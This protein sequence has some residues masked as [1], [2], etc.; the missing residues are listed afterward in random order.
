MAEDGL[1][2]D[3]RDFLESQRIECRSKGC[4][5][6]VYKRRFS[7]DYSISPTNLEEA[8]RESEGSHYGQEEDRVSGQYDFILYPTNV[9]T[10]HNPRPGSVGSTDSISE[11]IGQSGDSLNYPIN[12]PTGHNLRPDSVGSADSIPESV[13]QFGDSSEYPSESEAASSLGDGHPRITP[14]ESFRSHFLS[15]L[16]PEGLQHTP[17]ANGKMNSDSSYEE[18]PG[19]LM[20]AVNHTG[21]A[22]SQDLS[23]SKA[24]MPHS[25]GY[26]FGREE[27][28]SPFRWGGTQPLD[29][30][31]KSK[32]AS[33]AALRSQFSG[34]FCPFSP[35][36]SNTPKR[37]NQSRAPKK[38]VNVPSHSSS[39]VSKY[40]R[41]QLN[42]PLPDFSKVEPRVR[43]PKAE[44]TYRPPKG[45]NHSRQFQG[46]TRPLVFKSPAEIVR[47]VLLSSGDNSPQKASLPSYTV[48]RVPKEFKTPQQATELV[49]QLQEDYHRLLTKYAEA[50]NTIDQLRL[51][52]K[53]N[54]YSDPP[55]PS[56]GVHMG[57]MP[58]GTKVMSF[59]IPQ[60]RMAE[61]QSTTGS[62][63]LLDSELSAT[64]GDLNPSPA[65][66]YPGPLTEGSGTS[67]LG[68]SLGDRLTQTLANEV[69]RFLAQVESFEGLVQEG[70]LPPQDQLKRFWRLKEEQ[71]ALE[72]SFLWA[73]GEHRR[74]QQL[75]A[76]EV[77]PGKFDPNREVEGEIFR[78]GMRLE[79][80]MDE[81]DDLRPDQ[82][83][84]RTPPE[85]KSRGSSAASPVSDLP[86]L[87]PALS[88][89]AP[90]PAVCTPY[91]ETPA[92]QN[93]HTFLS[94]EH[95]EVSSASSEVENESPVLPQPLQYKQ[96]QMEQDF[97]SLMARCHSIKL[98]PDAV[99]LEEDQEEKNSTQE[100]D[101]PIAGNPNAFESSSRRTEQEKGK[102]PNH[103][104]ECVEQT[105]ST[106]P[107]DLQSS[108]GNGGHHLD[109]LPQGPVAQPPP[110]APQLTPPVSEQKQQ[111]SHQSS[112]AS[113]AG[114]GASGSLPLQKAFHLAST[115]Q[116]ARNFDV[117]Q[118]KD[119]RIVSPETDSGFVGSETSRISP[120][121]QTP[122]HQLSHTSVSFGTS[123]PRR[124][125][126]SSTA[127][128]PQAPSSHHP[129]RD[130]PVIRV[131]SGLSTS[132]AQ[133]QR[134]DPMPITP[135]K[136]WTKSFHHKMGPGTKMAHLDGEG[137]DRAREQ[138]SHGREDDQSPAA[139]PSDETPQEAAQHPLSNL[140]S[141]EVRD[142]AIRALQQEVTRLR[143]RIEA[144]LNSPPQDTSSHNFQ[145]ATRA[146]SRL[147]KE[148]LALGSCSHTSKSAER[149]QSDSGDTTQNNSTVRVQLRSSSVP[150]EEP[151]PAQ[152]IPASESEQSISRIQAEESRGEEQSPS[153]R[154][155]G[156]TKGKQ[157]DTVYFRG[158][159]T[160]HEYSVKSSQRFQADN[161]SHSC[162]RCH[163][164]R[165]KLPDNTLSKDPEELFPSDSMKKTQC[166]MCH[167]PRNPTERDK[168]PS[169][170][171]KGTQKGAPLSSGPA[172]KSEQRQQQSTSPSL[173]HPPGVWYLAPPLPAP[174][175]AT[176]AYVPPVPVVPYS[177]ST[178]YYS[179]VAPT[180]ASSPLHYSSGKK[181][182]KVR[183]LSQ[184]HRTP[185]PIPGHRCLSEMDLVDLDDLSLS[186]SQAVEAAKNVELTTKQMSRSLSADLHRARGL[187]GSCLF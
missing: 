110:P 148:P 61:W 38:G 121:T 176:F 130:K 57:S 129:G 177:P 126:Q 122:E 67:T 51:G 48:A 127:C 90:M 95:T 32:K 28:N 13:G 70:T 9:P 92:L 162:P 34:S 174:A 44:E 14:T 42:Y 161:N 184:S 171:D 116:L 76:S 144:S 139:T 31:Q 54:L 152:T 154:I 119:H 180:S 1:S 165:K 33:P 2:R 10:E 64:R 175:G 185:T 134:S 147:A 140:I 83:S 142:Q 124:L 29:Q 133:A 80:L 4:L 156:G 23:N 39:E 172:R 22:I 157:T 143:E 69:V 99:K 151:Q 137:H 71:D 60:A 186:L 97:Q 120:L 135:P 102:H 88:A 100:V 105:Q 73:R 56:H 66:A 17:S 125:P 159:Y 18:K 115:P 106:Q 173:P 98:F 146:Q 41:G 170:I 8:Q 25:P 62:Q 72:K 78:L 37:L 183:P 5:Q 128:L 108:P 94:G 149:Y 118:Y 158:L 112:I 93:G 169:G 131:S 49:Q 46:P 114:S 58:H 27:S 182:A 65:V 104:E 164:L 123:D 109:G 87:S 167:R 16:S 15:C 153:D 20:G 178:L 30:I 79:E 24:Q 91:P 6:R 84:L 155:K 166:P 74:V 181:P 50:E 163:S 52:A 187:R 150:W 3:T 101:G 82:L 141:R 59:T 145:Q 75:Q 96:L 63:A 77:P 53:I 45:K 47:E 55:K 21:C 35:P 85:E 7:S 107:L 19:S 179:P 26:K 40:G 86:T 103:L 136:K 89:H 81:I 43:F 36:K 12:A 160:G 168:E 138:H 132:G 111:P 117:S 113:L 11:S 68:P